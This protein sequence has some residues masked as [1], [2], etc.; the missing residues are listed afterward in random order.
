MSDTLEFRA[1]LCATKD[2]THTFGVAY[3]A[4]GGQ[5]PLR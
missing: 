5:H 4:E 2:G 3:V 1:I